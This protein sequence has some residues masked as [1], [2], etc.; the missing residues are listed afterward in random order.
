MS[1]DECQVIALKVLAFLM[2]EPDQANRFMG[3]TGGT[4]SGRRG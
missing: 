2:D 1:H 3:V 4:D